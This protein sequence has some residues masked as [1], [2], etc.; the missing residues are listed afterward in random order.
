MFNK[1]PMFF[2]V[3]KAIRCVTEVAEPCGVFEIEIMPL[4]LEARYTYILKAKNKDGVFRVFAVG[5]K[6][7]DTIEE[8][9]VEGFETLQ[10]ALS[11]DEVKKHLYD[12]VFS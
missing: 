3:L 4:L 5:R 7:Y 12:N 11:N 9:K 8:A 1:K 10:K 6:A 2:N